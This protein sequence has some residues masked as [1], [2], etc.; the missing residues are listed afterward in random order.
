MK[1]TT[2]SVNIAAILIAA[3][4][5]VTGLVYLL[6]QPISAQESQPTIETRLQ[7]AVDNGN[8]TQAAAN[9]RLKASRRSGLHR[10]KPQ[11]NLEDV[12][13]RI[14]AAVEVGTL[15]Q[16]QADAKLEK[17]EGALAQKGLHRG[18]PQ[19]NPEDL[20]SRIKRG[21]ESGAITQKD[22]SA[23]RERLSQGR[24]KQAA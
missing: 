10:G 3:I 16:D 8:I 14:Q 11:M 19:M 15:T 5:L 13:A 18:K 21:I 17:L 12:A 23:I 9:E 7:V 2:S 6:Y 4:A 24:S 20:E 22:A 1:S